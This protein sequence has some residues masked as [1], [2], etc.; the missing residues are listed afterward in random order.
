MASSSPRKPKQ[1]CPTRFE[2]T[3][4]FLFHA[5]SY[6]PRLTNRQQT[7]SLLHAPP[8]CTPLLLLLPPAIAGGLTMVPIEALQP[9]GTAAHT[10]AASA[11]LAMHFKAVWGSGAYWCN[12][13]HCYAHH[14]CI[15]SLSSALHSRHVHLS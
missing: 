10:T 1:E 3:S 2:I 15:C 7:V 12:S 14:C 9:T 5:V 11:P 8:M 4:A 13:R 6:T